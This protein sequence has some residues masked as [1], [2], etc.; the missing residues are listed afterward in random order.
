MSRPATRL[1][2][3]LATNVTALPSGLA[4]RPAP[5]RFP[6][7]SFFLAI[8]HLEK[9]MRNHVDYRYMNHHN[10]I[11]TAKQGQQETPASAS[12]TD[13]GNYYRLS[14]EAA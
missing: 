5:S 7:H 12:N 10:D 1:S 4:G 14:P 13:R 6:P 8:T 11:K 9:F 2:G 3:T